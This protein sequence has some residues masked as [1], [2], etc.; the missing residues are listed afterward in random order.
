ME[1]T[2]C[3]RE[4]IC[5]CYLQS[6]VTSSGTLLV[7]LT[8]CEQHSQ[9]MPPLSVQAKILALLYTALTSYTRGEEI[10]QNIQ[11]PLWVP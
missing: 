2:G 3:A 8:A 11:A 9:K 1:A 10:A 4:V 5:G 6:T 7:S